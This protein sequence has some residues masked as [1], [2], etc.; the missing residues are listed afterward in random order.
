[1]PQIFEMRPTALLPLRR[2]AR[3]GFFRLKI[4]RLRPDLNP[5]SWVPEI[6]E[7]L[8]LRKKLG[9]EIQF[10]VV[11]FQPS[12]DYSSRRE[13][14]AAFRPHSRLC[15]HLRQDWVSRHTAAGYGERRFYPCYI[16]TLLFFLG[17]R[18]AP[19]PTKVMVSCICFMFLTEKNGVP[20]WR[21]GGGTALQ[22]GRSRDRFPMVS[23]EFSLT[24][25]FRSH[26]GPG[27]DSASNQN[28]FLGVKAAGA[29]G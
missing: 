23:L 27:V 4:R 9:D 18:R 10:T 1:M 29:Y 16:D 12:A 6:T 22:T 8:T 20:R 28:Y 13:G 3:L 7:A 26:F 11:C 14:Q 19:T 17:R 21:S 15:P 2:K 5:R 24:Y 25:S